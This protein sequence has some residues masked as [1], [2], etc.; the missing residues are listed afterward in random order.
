MAEASMTVERTSIPVDEVT[1]TGVLEAFVELRTQ[2]AR[3]TAT[4]ARESGITSTDLRAATYISGDREATPKRIPHQLG[5]TTGAMTALIDRLETAGLVGRAL[6]PTDR[7]SKRLQVTEQGSTVLAELARVYGGA[8]S[9]ALET[10]DL[11][12][13]RDELSR[14]ADALRH[15]TQAR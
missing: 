6:H 3:L 8:F 15:A 10:S 14:I 5:L 13:V 7:R 1:I 2:A 12:R 4:M 9:S 11:R